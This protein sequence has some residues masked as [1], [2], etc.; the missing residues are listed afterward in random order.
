ML[1]VVG[2]ALF[3]SCDEEK[4]NAVVPIGGG[5]TE[6]ITSA[7][8][9][10]NIQKD[11]GNPLS[12]TK[13]VLT[14]KA[15]GMV[16]DLTDK[17]DNPQ[18]TLTLELP[19]ETKPEAY[20]V[21]AIDENGSFYDGTV[22]IRVMPERTAVCTATL[23]MR[24]NPTVTPLTM[25][26][27][28][29]GTTITLYF[30]NGMTLQ[31][32]GI[33]YSVNGDTPQTIAANTS[34]SA[35]IT[36]LAAGDVVTFYSKNA[37]LGGYSSNVR[38]HI[39]IVPDKLCYVYGNVMSII[40]DGTEG[41]ENDVDISGDYALYG[42]FLGSQDKIASHADYQ[43]K[44][45]ATTLTRFCYA[46]MFKGCT[47]ISFAPALPCQTLKESCYESM[48]QDCKSLQRPPKLPATSLA[49]SCYQDM[50]AGCSSLSTA[51]ALPATTLQSYCYYAMFQDC[52]SL[53]RAPDLPAVAL[54]NKCYA[55][56]FKG[57]L[58]LNY[59]RCLARTKITNCTDWVKGVG[60]NGTFVCTKDIGWPTGDSG[61][62]SGWV[63]ETDG[64]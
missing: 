36:G 62:P 31:N 13:L 33:D 27:T 52:V 53:E 15:S 17:L 43:L 57:C 60:T 30:R 37:S 45:P 39:S 44:L 48:Y 4:D 26:A 8:V 32:G 10:L 1:I 19:I 3:A 46:Y 12:V 7:K 20:A 2:M 51:P 54:P 34:E 49:A 21:S 28:E 24:F 64:L 18:Q 11:D 61:I 6:V 23:T 59:I 56:M 40:D 9:I 50:F 25:E 47:T 41:F 14:G 42:L 58:N 38:R 22:N 63:R 35:S 55:S 5:E 29:D 16:M